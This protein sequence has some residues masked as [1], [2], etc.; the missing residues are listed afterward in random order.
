MLCIVGFRARQR[1]LS[2]FPSSPEYLYH[3]AQTFP[4][5]RPRAIADGALH[6]LETDPRPGVEIDL[7]QVP[8]AFDPRELASAWKR[9]E[10]AFGI[11]TEEQAA[12]DKAR[13]GRR[14]YICP[15]LDWPWDAENHATARPNE[16]ATPLGDGERHGPRAELARFLR[17]E[18]EDWLAARKWLSNIFARSLGP[19]PLMPRHGRR[20]DAETFGRMER[21]PCTAVGMWLFPLEAFKKPTIVQRSCF[22]LSAARP[23]LMLFEV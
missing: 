16:P 20:M 9:L 18:D 8:L 23:G 14:L 17:K 10:Q 3:F 6:W 22:D 5:A 19:A 1:G 7:R 13:I 12:Q 15:V 21:L 11:T 2:E 4:L